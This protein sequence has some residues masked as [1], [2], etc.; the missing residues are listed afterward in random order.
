MNALSR[1]WD[2]I[3]YTLALLLLAWIAPMAIIIYCNIGI[4]NNNKTNNKEI[5]SIMNKR[6]VNLSPTEIQLR[7]QFIICELI[8]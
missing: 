7:R 8:F 2:D 4:V 3:T 1:D 6:K 5:I